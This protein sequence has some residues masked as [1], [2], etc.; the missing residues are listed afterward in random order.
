MNTTSEFAIAVTHFFKGA[1]RMT[2]F[3]KKSRGV[4]RG[5]IHSEHQRRLAIVEQLY[6]LHENLMRDSTAAASDV[7]AVPPDNWINEQLARLGEDWRVQ[8]VDGY[9]YEIYE[10][11]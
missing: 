11:A 10:A 8:N 6:R 7:F 2:G 3:E 5:S 1:P 4:S 9:R